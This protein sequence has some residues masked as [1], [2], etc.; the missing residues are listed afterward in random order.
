[1]SKFIDSSAPSPGRLERIMAA[2]TSVDPSVASAPAG[3][4]EH[5]AAQR[6]HDVVLIEGDRV[7]TWSELNEQADR[8]ATALHERGVRAGDI[9]GV[10]T[11]VRSEWP[12][13]VHALTKLGASLLG[14]NWRLTP[15]EV[16]FVLEDSRAVG[17]IADGADLAALQPVALDCGLKVAVSV[18]GAQPG[19]EAYAE[20]LR[21]EPR[22]WI[23]AGEAP[24]VVYTSGTTGKPKGV[25]MDRNA[26]DRPGLREYLQDLSRGSRGYTIDSVVLVSMPLHHG[27]GPSQVRGALRAGA[28]LVLQ[29]RFDAADTLRLI[30]R[31]RVTHWSGVPTMYKRIAALPENVLRRHDVSSLRALGIG[32]APVPMPLKR[33]I[34]EH[35]G[36]ILSEGYG[37]TETSMI[38]A[39]AP[40]LQLV[41][42]GSS[43]L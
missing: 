39:L 22:R 34:I 18:D 20:L 8:L 5:W 38:T 10:R 9:V 36:P 3:T 13:I 14:I 43:G 25:F 29:P 1:T 15:A 12:A 17:L 21:T 16:R 31:H 26:G 27:S 6:P 33:W 42:P 7:T 40:E 24:L 32:A 23:G 19:F 11:R 37:S 2:S 30:E 4:L 35:F 41:K 28:R